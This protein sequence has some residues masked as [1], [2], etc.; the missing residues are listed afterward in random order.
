MTKSQKSALRK[1]YADVSDGQIHY[2]EREGTDPP[3]VFLHQTA[4]SAGSFDP[5]LRALD[6]KNRLIALDTPGF[7]GS[8]DPDGEP[9]L[10]DYARW[11]LDALNV[12]G[13]ER[14][15]LFGHHTGASLAVEMARMEPS[16]GISIM[17]AGPV[18]MTD[19]ERAEFE[20]G[21]RD[22]IAPE[23]SGAHLQT[24]WDYA[25][26][27]NPDCPV[28]ILHGEVVSMLRAWRGR[29]Q[30]YLAVARHDTAEAANGLDLPVL[31]LTSP[32]DFFH[33]MLGRAVDLFPDATAA[34]TAGG[35][36]QATADPEGV[37]AAVEHFLTDQSGTATGS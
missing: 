11:A 35:N 7:G 16:R 33:E 23:R 13:V 27:Y 31:L 12:L 34:T 8:F 36:F 2:H 25:A 20:A 37:A 28:E 14:A 1:G 9:M 6:C 3:I 15:H 26:K 10:G 29:A 4:S 5:L 18:F 32:D 24:N 19:A 30:A 22:A 17:L 21:Y